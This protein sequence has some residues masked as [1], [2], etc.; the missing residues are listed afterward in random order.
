MESRRTRALDPR[1]LSTMHQ[2]NIKLL[3]NLLRIMLRLLYQGSQ[4]FR[5]RC[6]L[7]FLLQENHCRL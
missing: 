5:R 3:S 6:L 2:L 1:H 7:L 4:R